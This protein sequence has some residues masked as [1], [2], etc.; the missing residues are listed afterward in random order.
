MH[1]LNS[2]NINNEIIELGYPNEI[3]PTL[4]LTKS[5]PSLFNVEFDMRVVLSP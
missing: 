2:I 1:I 4:F 3:T 5:L